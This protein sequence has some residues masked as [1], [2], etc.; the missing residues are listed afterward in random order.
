MRMVGRSWT[1]VA[2]ALILTVFAAAACS[3]E[4][5]DWKNAERNSAEYGY[6]L[7]L[8]KYPQGEHAAA[9]KVKIEEFAYNV[10]LDDSAHPGVGKIDRLREFLKQYPE[11]AFAAKARESIEEWE[12]EA[13][14]AQGSL[15]AFEGYL[16]AHPQGRHAEEA[17]ARIKAV[18]DARPPEWRDVR[19][20]KFVLRQSFD[21]E[22]K[23]VTIGF[24]AE[25]TKFYP[26]IGIKKA[27]SDAPADAVLTVTSVGEPHGANY[28][29][30]GFGSGTFYYTGARVSGRA[31]LEIPGKKT[32]REDFDGTE[33]IPGSITGGGA[34]EASGAP[35]ASAMLKDFPKKAGRLLAR[36]F[37][38]VPMIGALGSRDSDVISGAVL[39]LQKGGLPALELLLPAV[40]NPDA[41]IRVNAARALKGHMSAGSIAALVK[42]LGREGD[43]EKELRDAAAESLAALGAIAVPALV[44]ASRDAKAVIREGA[45]AALG[46]IRTAPS[47]AL[48]TALFDDADKPVREAAIRS[49]GEHK[50]R[51]AVAALIERLGAAKGGD[52]ALWLSAIE[53]SLEATVPGDEE[54]ETVSVS[55]LDWDRDL[56]GR[57]A[58]KVPGL[59]DDAGLRDRAA[60]LFYRIG[61]SVIGAVGPMTRAGAP[62]IRIWAADVIG[63]L[64]ESANLRLLV[65][66]AG[67]PDAGVRLQAAKSFANF[68]NESGAIEPLSRL[69]L[70]ASPQV[71]KAALLGL[72]QA[73]PI[74]DHRSA[75]RRNFA[76]ADKI[77]LL[78][79]KLTPAGQ[80]QADEKTAAAS[81]LGAVGR[82]AVGPLSAAL[83][84]AEPSARV[85]IV[86]ALG[87]TGDSQAGPALADLAKD[88]AAQADNAL[89]AAIYKSLGETK[90]PQALDILSAGAKDANGDR[91]VA[92]VEALRELGNIRG[93]DAIVALLPTDNAM[94]A[95]AIDTALR[96]LTKYEPEDEKF[97]WKAW[98]AKSRGKYGLK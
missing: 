67:D 47:L 70:D 81:V 82:A 38:Y 19:T 11:G 43:A 42:C 87:K 15:V 24:E 53:N 45:A 90:S 8:E 46:G 7:Y 23:D 44:E 54:D 31:V 6:L 88:P 96:E 3:P 22:V 55:S 1:K 13:G 56:V 20:V 26:F 9:A 4:K 85:T 52:R 95:N 92:A 97:D 30:F 72:G 75:F 37:G 86:E 77:K 2:V 40:E 27:D 78:I 60:G 36:A 21:E 51:A 62:E 94:L 28:S 14:A 98:W 71:A 58:A 74:E 65:P 49:A 89:M 12:W 76:S 17:R 35:F 79:D 93:V 33:P 50:S 41:D 29:M 18:L 69:M 64:S 16:A 80:E 5:R 61:E 91:M 48:L 63:R 83:K 66:L 10:A 73:A 32:I 59:V 57:M 25:L 39:A 68:S 84:G 34:S